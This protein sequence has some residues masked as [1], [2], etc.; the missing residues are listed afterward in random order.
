MS[1]RR[2]HFEHVLVPRS[3]QQAVSTWEPQHALRGAVWPRRVRPKY[4]IVCGTKLRTRNDARSWRTYP[5]VWMDQC[6]A[7]GC[8]FVLIT[9]KPRWRVAA[10]K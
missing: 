8:A 5:Q 1:G 9:F 10:G 6:P 7:A 2:R 3:E 4:C